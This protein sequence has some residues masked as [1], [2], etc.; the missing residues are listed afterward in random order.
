MLL[1]ALTIS[2][3]GPKIDSY[4][5]VRQSGLPFGITDYGGSHVLD[6]LQSADP[7]I[8]EIA[9]DMIFVETK[10]GAL[11]DVRSGDLVYGGLFRV[12]STIVPFYLTDDSGNPEVSFCKSDEWMIR[13]YSSYFVK[14]SPLTQYYD[15][16]IHSA[17]AS[18]LNLKWKRD[19]INELASDHKISHQKTSKKVVAL[20]LDN[21]QSSFILLGFG[22][23]LSILVWLGELYGTIRRI[24]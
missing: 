5:K 7:I 11:E 4:E 22:T 9:E 14:R 13:M 1:S 17:I 21:L 10:R 6:F 20:S 23:V 18:G 3:M 12:F 2:P 15:K 19:V 8:R 24:C 16:F